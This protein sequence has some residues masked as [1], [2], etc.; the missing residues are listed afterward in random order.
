[1]DRYPADVVKGL[2]ASISSA[3][4]RKDC[5]GRKVKGRLNRPFVVIPVQSAKGHTEHRAVFPDPFAIASDAPGYLVAYLFI[6]QPF[7]D[8][9][10][11][12]MDPEFHKR[13]TLKSPY[14][15][16]RQKEFIFLFEV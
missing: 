6:S 10:G 11:A 1:M 2:S 4:C 12:S 5:S 13:T 9:V 15:F 7:H 16:I 14:I 8:R 3:V